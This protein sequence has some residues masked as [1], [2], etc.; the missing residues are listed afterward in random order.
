MW[1]G[2]VESTSLLKWLLEES[3]AHVTA[4]QIL[5]QSPEKRS[6]NEAEATLALMARLKEIRT[7]DYR[8]SRVA[9]DNGRVTPVDYALHYAIALPILVQQG[10]DFLFRGL[11]QEDFNAPIMG[12]RQGESPAQVHARRLQGLQALQPELDLQ[13]VSPLLS[14]MTMPKWWHVKYLGHLAP[15][16]WS[17]R[18]PTAEMLPCH[19]CH[20]CVE[21]RTAM[22]VA[23][24]LVGVKAPPEWKRELWRS[25]SG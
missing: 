8:N 13:H 12:R 23:N 24:S 19:R 15:M 17:C 25:P 20:S 4:H 6:P 5:I 7:F 2:G 16:T 3:A 11:C 10:F 1:S 18:R 22:G 9:I 21:R 14:I